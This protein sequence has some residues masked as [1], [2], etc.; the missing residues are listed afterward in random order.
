MMDFRFINQWMPILN[1]CLQYFSM[2]VQKKNELRSEKDLTQNL[3]V[4]LNFEVF[5]AYYLSEKL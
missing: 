1:R 4:F 2:D 5:Y 3:R